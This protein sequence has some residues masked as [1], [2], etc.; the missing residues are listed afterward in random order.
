MLKMLVQAPHQDGPLRDSYKCRISGPNA[1]LQ[2]QNPS[3]WEMSG[4]FKCGK[5]CSSTR[6]PTMAVHEAIWVLWKMLKPGLT[7][8]ACM[9]PGIGV[10]L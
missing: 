6:A 2:G 7:E 8:V 4:R 1:D 5:H 3:V 9:Q 10:V